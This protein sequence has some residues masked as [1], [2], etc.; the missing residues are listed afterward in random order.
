[1]AD[2]SP[3]IFYVPNEF[4][5]FRQL[6]FRDPLESLVRAGQ[7]AELGTFS[8]LDAIRNGG[9]AE[10]H[11]KELV[12]RVTDF[13]PDILLM[14]HLGHTGLRRH[15]FASLRQACPRDFIYHEAD[16]YSRHL[17]P[18]PPEARAAARV[19]DVVFTVGSGMFSDNFR[20]AG[21][22]NVRW[23]PSAYEPTRT[24]NF[25]RPVRQERPHDVVIVA[26]R[27]RPRFR[28]LPDWRERIRFVELMQQHFGERLAVYGRGWDGPTA[29]GP[30]PFEAQD[31]AITSGWVSANWDHFASEA[32]YFSNRL[33]ISLAAG[34]IH[35][36]TDH[37][38]YDQL[39]PA[40]TRRFL[41]RGRTPEELVDSIERVLADTTTEDR[42]GAIA[43]GREFAAEHFRQDDLM[44]QMMNWRK[45]WIDPA[46]ARSVWAAERGGRT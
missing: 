24:S 7:V 25:D 4:G 18:I 35:A 45:Q 15:H 22:T 38:G 1:M 17:H 31:E 37:P 42:L 28:G 11:R 39:F 8:V 43:A 33:P 36:T 19:A 46:D 23:I 41:V 16:P 5:G 13:Q 40:Q 30:V 34:S 3:R 26:N 12:R 14:Q 2:A 9:D 6:G 29:K 20:R 27:N 21:S 44:V 32:S 10:A